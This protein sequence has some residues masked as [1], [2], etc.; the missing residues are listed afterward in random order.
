VI[1][2]PSNLL[3][4]TFQ[5]EAPVIAD[6]G[7]RSVKMMSAVFQ[8]N[9]NSVTVRSL[10][11]DAIGGAVDSDV[12]EV[13]LYID[14]D[15]NGIPSAPDVLLGRGPITSGRIVFSGFQL[16]VTAGS[17]VQLIVLID[18]SAN[19][20][21]D[22]RVGL[23]VLETSYLQVAPPDIVA[24][25]PSRYTSLLVNRAPAATGLSAEGA[26]SG[27]AA[28]LHI[29]NPQPRLAWSYSDPNA[30]DFAQ[31][32]YNVSVTALP[33]GLI[34][35][36]NGTGTTSS[37]VYNGTALA[38]GARYRM[39]IRVFDRRLWGTP[40]SLEIR[41]NTPPPAPILS[42]PPDN[43]VNQGPD[44][45]AL[46]WNAVADAEGDSASYRWTLATRAD[47]VGA[48]T[49]MTAPGSTSATVATAGAT[50]YYWRIE[51]FDQYEWGPASTTW[52]F[53]TH[54][55]AGR[56]FGRVVHAGSGLIAVVQLYNSAGNPAG[57][58]TTSA[59][60]DGSFAISD[61]PFGTYEVRVTSQGYQSKTLGVTLT[62][63][64]PN[65]DLGDIDLTPNALGG[66]EW[67]TIALFG[68]FIAAIAAVIAVV[69]V[70][71]GRRRRAAVRESAPRPG[72]T[73]PPTAPT[74]EGV[75]A[76]QLAFECPEC[77]T[78]VT[79]DAKSCPGCGALF[80]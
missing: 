74:A 18:I 52:S 11:I 42:G 17:P 80:E 66:I 9:A 13:R 14:V 47:F 5:D 16:N 8:A 73:G 58:T 12:A 43:A 23:R 59:N 32:A 34:W 67:T 78:G 35:W 29:M 4:A 64:T 19:A 38:D 27:T 49:G 50:K 7:Q 57:S 6:A 39:D 70:V 53:T 56:V 3:L 48:V 54:A 69:A 61:L 62:L 63:S 41:M 20:A 30:N 31:A 40:A 22:D 68:L 10:R 46:Q 65:V 44:S 37:I 25:F 55:A 77:G 2:E 75:A 1:S 76:E 26:T 28:V 45:V 36:V 72:P 71:V 21:A 24:P 15:G 51:A 33:G 79:A 60:G